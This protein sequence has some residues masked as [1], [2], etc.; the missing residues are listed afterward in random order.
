MNNVIDL[1]ALF[2]RLRNLRAIQ[3]PE[4]HAIR[5]KARL[6]RLRQGPPRPPVKLGGGFLS[7]NPRRRDR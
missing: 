5:E 3:S 7:E 1:R 4:A 2:L 6:D